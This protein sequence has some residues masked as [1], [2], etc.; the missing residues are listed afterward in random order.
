M[1]KGFTI[2]IIPDEPDYEPDIKFHISYIESIINSINEVF[3]SIFELVTFAGTETIPP[4]K[5]F[6]HNILAKI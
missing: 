1:E 3:P 5:C 6:L 4:D 2:N